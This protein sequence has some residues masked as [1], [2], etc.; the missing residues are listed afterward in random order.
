MIVIRLVNNNVDMSI[1]FKKNK[2]HQQQR[3]KEITKMSGITIKI[4]QYY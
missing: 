3:K 4:L 2:Q 1:V